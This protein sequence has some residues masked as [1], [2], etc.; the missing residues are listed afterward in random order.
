MRKFL[1]YSLGAY[2]GKH[3]VEECI[4]ASTGC[5]SHRCPVEAFGKLP[6][7]I[8]S[9]K[10][11]LY[12]ENGVAYNG[13]FWFTCPWKFLWCRQYDLCSATTTKCKMDVLYKKTT[14]CIQPAYRS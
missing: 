9:Q 8:V 10:L 11:P 3:P 5:F 1:V 6:M 2:I 13:C 14:S 4:D 7:D 12:A